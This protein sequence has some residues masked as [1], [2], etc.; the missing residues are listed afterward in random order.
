[1]TI[2]STIMSKCLGQLY[3]NM[4]PLSF[5]LKNALL[6]CYVVTM[7]L[8]NF[9]FKIRLCR[10]MLYPLSCNVVFSVSIVDSKVCFSN[11]LLISFSN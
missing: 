11:N 10:I 5:L 7:S 4:A 9:F 3:L 8:P 2:S 1:M 6:V